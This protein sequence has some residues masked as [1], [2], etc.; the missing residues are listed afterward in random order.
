MPPAVVWIGIDVS[1]KDLQI[2]SGSPGVELP[3]RLPNSPAE[4]A[5]LAGHLAGGPAVHVV[6]EASGGYDMPLLLHL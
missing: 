2:H 3:G 1:K 6:F 4:L 5:A